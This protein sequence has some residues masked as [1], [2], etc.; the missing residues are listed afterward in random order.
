MLL[1]N[2][3]GSFATATAFATSGMPN[4]VALG[5]VDQ[6]GDL[7]IVATVAGSVAVL[8][9]DGHGGFGA[10]TTYA[11]GGGAY[12]LALYDLDGDGSLDIVTANQAGDAVAVLLGNGSGGFA[13][14]TT[15]A[16]GD[17]ARAVKLG[18][19]DNARVTTEDTAIVFNAA[20]G[21]AITL[22]DVDAGGLDER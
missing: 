22:G 10:Q 3:T 13:A 21:N 5:D 6:D 8:L 14:P 9:G 19:L 17:G 18:D 1:G 20:H 12:D 4:S 2:G 15:F 16:A 7:D 11:A